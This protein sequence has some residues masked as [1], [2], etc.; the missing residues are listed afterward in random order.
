MYVIIRYMLLTSMY[1]I[2]RYVNNNIL[3]TDLNVVY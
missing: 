3:F 2:T 1:V